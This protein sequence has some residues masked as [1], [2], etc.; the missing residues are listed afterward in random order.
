MNWIFFILFILIYTVADPIFSE[1]LFQE[2]P[3]YFCSRYYHRTGGIGS[4]TPLNGVSGVLL[5]VS[6][7]VCNFVIIHLLGAITKNRAGF[8]VGFGC[9]ICKLHGYDMYDCYY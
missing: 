1:L 7:F 6:S 5:S 3:N 2:I 4:R 9:V 8:G